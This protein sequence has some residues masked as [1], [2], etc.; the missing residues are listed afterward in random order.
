M[1]HVSQE[2]G[3]GLVGGFGTLL[4]ILQLFCPVLHL[5]LKLASFGFNASYPPSKSCSKYGYG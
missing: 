1:G 2:D 4:R 5:Y 3:F